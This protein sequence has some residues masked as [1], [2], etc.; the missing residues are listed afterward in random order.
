MPRCPENARSERTNPQRRPA[1]HCAGSPSYST[2]PRADSRV[3]AADRGGDTVELSVVDDVWLQEG[4]A[5]GKPFL[6][7][8]A[9]HYDS[10]VRAVDLYFKAL[11][12]A[13]T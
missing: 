9:C 4:M 13:F 10:G 6:A 1:A 8:L 2:P 11:G 12:S 3:G 5:F 7:T